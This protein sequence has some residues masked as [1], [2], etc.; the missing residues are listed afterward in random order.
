MATQVVPSGPPRKRGS[1]SGIYRLQSRKPHSTLSLL[2]KRVS[3][4]SQ[5]STQ[6]TEEIPYKKRKISDSQ[7]DLAVENDKIKLFHQLRELES[8]L[9]TEIK[10]EQEA[11]QVLFTT[12]APKVKGILR[13]H[14][15]NTHTNQN[16][17]DQQPFWSLRLQ[18]RLVY[19]DM[20][21]LHNKPKLEPGYVKKFSSYFR[22]IQILFPNGEKIEWEKQSIPRETDGIELKRPGNTEMDIRILLVL[23]NNPPKFKLSRPLACFIGAS[24]ET[25]ENIMIVLWEYIKTHR[26]LDSDD[27]R[28]INT[29]SRLRT[30]FPEERLEISTIVGKI[31]KHLAEHDPIEIV[32]KLKLSA[33]W[34]ETEHVY[35]IS[36]DVEDPLQYELAA[37]LSAL[38]SVIYAP[39]SFTNFMPALR[40]SKS[41]EVPKNPME[42]SLTEIDAKIEKEL[43]ELQKHENRRVFYKKL[44]QSP[45]DTI[46]NLVK[47]QDS[48]VRKLHTTSI[49]E[50]LNK[51]L[52]HEEHAAS[53]FK[54][55]FVGDLVERYV[56]NNLA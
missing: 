25:Q 7:P 41:M 16:R 55:Q 1:A 54:E 40:A 33:D 36:V 15:Y 44:I 12:T 19:P 37:S 9:D 27:K 3:K 53:F 56:S 38:N 24:E 21:K 39:N 20:S 14:I 13:I 31:R 46:E 48:C 28:F 11:I 22:K 43:K 51:E 32:H 34:T 26:L 47:E 17:R 29:D 49:Y 8:E 52:G 30:I 6:D 5:K 35:D 42:N 23:D 2:S 45:R 10:K 4:Y 50:E 18:G